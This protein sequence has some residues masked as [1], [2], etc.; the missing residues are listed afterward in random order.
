MTIL[1]YLLRDAL[2]LW[3]Y[4]GADQLSATVAYYALF[5]IV[6]IIFYSVYFVGSLYGEEMVINALLAW[7]SGMGA[8]VLRLLEEA[9][10]NFAESAPGTITIMLWIGLFVATIIAFFNALI[11]GFHRLFGVPH[12]GV[13]GV[14]QKIA[15]SF[16][17]FFVLQV[18]IV[19]IIALEFLFAVFGG[20]ILF[21]SYIL[22]L[23]YFGGLTILLTIWYHMLT[24]D[25][26]PALPSRFYGAMIASLCFVVSRAFVSL[27][28]ALAP[29]PDLFGAAGMLII[30][31][32]WI[33]VSVTFIYFGAAFAQVHHLRYHRTK[34]Q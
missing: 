28:I 14:L 8:G 3:Y 20:Y 23:L 19:I 22:S 12:Q 29:V 31:L 11:E 30:L 7:G 4:R 1:L 18:F 6:P 27:H 34:N 15:R 5:A 10:R 24:L 33:Y 17:C 21:G 2:L 25:T 16:F 26:P 32:L 9:V 13:G